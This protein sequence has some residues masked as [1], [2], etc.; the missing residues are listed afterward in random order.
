MGLERGLADEQARMEGNMSASSGEPASVAAAKG[1]RPGTGEPYTAAQP[2]IADRCPSCGAQS[3]FVGAGGWLTCSVIGCKNPGVSDEIGVLKRSLRSAL[4]GEDW[5]EREC[6]RLR[7]LLAEQAAP[8]APRYCVVRYSEGFKVF[9]GKRLVEERELAALLNAK[10]AA[11]ACTGCYSNPCIC[12]TL[13]EPAPELRAAA[14]LRL[15]HIQAD[16][17]SDWVEAASVA[18]AVRIWRAAKIEEYGATD[19]GWW[20]TTEPDSVHMVSDE[21][22][23]RD[24]AAVR[25][26]GS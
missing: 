18:D 17:E 4:S 1:D 23:I 21:P 14:E 5:Q 10:S 2:K 12:T 24:A 22:V 25:A 8:A 7:N 11:P 13:A 16:G 26:G 9:E 3:L 15:Y 6:T 19:S 20:E